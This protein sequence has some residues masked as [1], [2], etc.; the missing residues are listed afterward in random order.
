[1][2]AANTWCPVCQV[3]LATPLGKA[4]PVCTGRG[5]HVAEPAPVLRD[6]AVARVPVPPREKRWWRR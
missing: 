1:M 5:R 4:C 6:P 3:H 2:T